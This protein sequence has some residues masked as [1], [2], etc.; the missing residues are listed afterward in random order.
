M[1]WLAILFCVLTLGAQ[2]AREVRVQVLMTADLH[3]HVLPQDSYTLQ[4][5]NHGWAKLATLIRG[6]RTAN[7]NT[8][9]VDCGDATQGE[10][11]TIF[12]LLPPKLPTDSISRVNLLCAGGDGI[13]D[14]AYLF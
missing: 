14:F 10:P 11:Q 2:E 6:L 13:C 1:Q 4:P 12:A 8:V 3:G 9:A 5:A 7:P